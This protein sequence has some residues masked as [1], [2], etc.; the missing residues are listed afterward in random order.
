MESLKLE[1]LTENEMKNANGGWHLVAG[2]LIGAALTQDLD[3]L[4]DAFMEG[5]EAGRS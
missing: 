5:Y 2:A 1:H 4:G 3:D